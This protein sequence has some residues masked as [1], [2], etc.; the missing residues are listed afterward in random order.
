MPTTT[1]LT[2]PMRTLVALIGLL[3]ATV[4]GLAQERLAP[5]KADSTIVIAHRGASGYLPEHTLPAKALAV[6]MGADFIEQDVVLSRD[7]HPIVIHDIHLDRVT[8]VAEQYPGR[9]RADGRYYVIDFDLAE[10]RRLRVH[11]RTNAS[12]DT[13]V[14]PQ[15]FP[16]DQS[17]F[18]LHTLAEELELLRGLSQSLQRP[19]GIYPEVKQPAWHRQQGY[20]PSRIVLDTLRQYYGE[21]QRD[22]VFVQCFELAE[23]QRI[24]QQL[25]CP[26]R[27]I[28][29]LGQRDVHR[30][31]EAFVFSDRKLSVDDV[32]RFCDGVGP[33][34]NVLRDGGFSREGKWNDLGRQLHDANLLLHPYTLRA[35]ALPAGVADF[36]ALVRQL[37]DDA[38]VDGFF[39]DHPDRAVRAL[40]NATR[41]GT[42]RAR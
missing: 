8:D 9:A 2:R 39:T 19:I 16:L 5:Q 7:R 26:Y 37:V 24:R 35:D 36:D 29:L 15:R 41:S 28:W 21:D 6:G 10:L 38:N 11:E 3:C 33:D 4:D 30:Q 17:R 31:G 13:R 32:A 23:V 14:Y 42:R 20:D 1:V 12:G 22:Q 34:L 18:S 27:L 25:Q 40:G